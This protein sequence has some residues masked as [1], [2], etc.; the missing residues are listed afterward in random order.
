[1]DDK[2]WEELKGERWS[3]EFPNM[4]D[5]SLESVQT[6]DKLETVDGHQPTTLKTSRLGSESRNARRT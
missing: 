1:M 3:I 2:K 4:K 6:T 5:V